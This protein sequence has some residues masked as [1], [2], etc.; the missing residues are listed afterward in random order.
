MDCYLSARLSPLIACSTA[1]ASVASGIW[2]GRAKTLVV[3]LDVENTESVDT[4]LGVSSRGE[5]IRVG[6]SLRLAKATNPEEHYGNLDIH[7]MT[8]DAFTSS[9]VALGG[10]RSPQVLIMTPSG[11][12]TLL[13][14]SLPSDLPAESGDGEG[15]RMR[16]D[17]VPDTLTSDGRGALYYLAWCEVPNQSGVP[18]KQY[19]IR[20]LQL[21]QS[22]RRQPAPQQQAQTQGDAGGS[23]A[24]GAQAQA[25]GGPAA[26]A[27]ARAAGGGIT[28]RSWQLPE[29][30]CQAVLK[31]RGG[32]W[33]MLLAGF[34]E[35]TGGAAVD[36]PGGEAQ[37]VGVMSNLAVDG[38]G[39]VLL[40]D[41]GWEPAPGAQGPTMGAVRRIRPGNGA[42]TTVARLKCPAAHAVICLTGTG[43]LCASWA[44]ACDGTV[45][46]LG[47][48]PPAHLQQPQ[49][50][51]SL[52][53]PLSANLADVSA[54]DLTI[55]VGERRFPCHRTILAAR[56][57]YFKHRL[58]SD[59]FADARAAELEL[60]DADPDAFE[61]LLR[62]LYTGGAAAAIPAEH[63]RSVAEL[64][65]RLLLPELC[66]AALASVAG[67]VT[68]ATVLDAA[69]LGYR[70]NG[71][72]VVAP[73]G[74]PTAARSAESAAVGA[75]CVLVANQ[76]NKTA[77]I[78][79][80]QSGG[81]D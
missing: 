76:G 34:E 58:A 75:S 15:P 53:R 7:S 16:Y 38:H 20:K 54:A 79:A 37:F 5:A 46:D 14:A 21:P 60:P 24:G 27:P 1:P 59:A 62:W 61:L 64:A 57:D 81:S 48:A 28:D 66:A 80:Q 69:L 72:A 71:I 19:A 41:K 78:A 3:R 39:H 31:D 44:D 6:P 36:G 65:D 47:L 70:G 18:F 68:A 51:A 29:D 11:D 35:G 52:M 43:F 9:F 49:P 10:E 2:A 56:C 4:V 33:G 74:N 32:I 23:T 12:D 45:F 40:L 17:R 55:C 25:E 42:V 8:W 63:A 22:M 73:L 26:G 50:A 77:C 30:W 67:S 13:V